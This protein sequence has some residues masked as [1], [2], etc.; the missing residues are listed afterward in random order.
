MI[1]SNTR[2][3]RS[4]YSSPAQNGSSGAGGGPLESSKSSNEASR[5][6]MQRWLE[7]EVQNKATF[8]EAGFSRYG[9]LE[10]MQ[11]LGT[12]PKGSVVKKTNGLAT[13][14]VKERTPKI[15]LKASSS[16]G[17]NSGSSAGNSSSKEKGGVTTALNTSSSSDIGKR[18]QP[19]SSTHISTSPRTS[20]PPKSQPPNVSAE[21]SSIRGILPELAPPRPTARRSV[22]LRDLEDT[23]YE[24]SANP[25]S[26]ATQPSLRT[27]LSRRSSRPTAGRT[28]ALILTPTGSTVG[29]MA[30]GDGDTNDDI[31]KVVKEAIVQA[32]R[33][34]RYPTAWA[35]ESLWEERS[36]DP[37]F[38]SM[39][40]DVFYQRADADTYAKFATLVSE[41]KREGKK[42]N[43]ACYHFV[44]PATSSGVVVHSPKPAPFGNLLT[45]EFSTVQNMDSDLRA[46]KK[47]KASHHESPSMLRSRRRERERESG[48][49]ET[50]GKFATPRGFGSRK[51]SDSHSSDSSLSSAISLSSPEIHTT[52]AARRGK[53]RTVRSSPFGFGGH[54][55]RDHASL[56]AAAPSGGT[57]MALQAVA[58]GAAE[59]STSSHG[60]TWRGAAPSR[61][62]PIKSAG[63]T[64]D[65]QRS[66]SPQS[67]PAV[68]SAAPSPKKQNRDHNTT[69]SLSPTHPGHASHDT[70]APMPGIVDQ[71]LFP[72]RPTAKSPSSS[73]SSRVATGSG[74]GMKDDG[75]AAPI[76]RS[77]ESLMPDAANGLRAT[78]DDS[79]NDAFDGPITG[80]SRRSR[81]ANKPPP[82]Y[83]Y[84]RRSTR[85]RSH[86]ELEGTASPTALSF[87]LASARTSR[88]PTPALPPAKRQRTGPRVKES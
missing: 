43:K 88:A 59:G 19:A 52:S 77:R 58:G 6:F 84:S 55:N 18:A 44:R 64:L 45:A 76:S 83:N 61:S 81:T 51:R 17:N 67:Q 39:V 69:G 66:H 3:S 63:K 74:T 57:D 12:F 37:K 33:F 11:P 56:S 41:K 32:L 21:T 65:S 8:E 80:T 38:V 34:Y 48:I 68:Q 73:S 49:R 40:E 13:E 10:N 29:I 46:H 86:D 16:S 15:I 85:K 2:A 36:S 1:S 53:F 79:S 24:P 47:H 5:T 7:P 25:R 9:V 70:S 28:S 23:D 22:S 20:L 75:Y 60:E 26:Q 35:L 14:S 31:C 30:A 87:T 54:V 72:N 82:V 62:E 71:P 50:S 27:P 78:A 4:R 42:E